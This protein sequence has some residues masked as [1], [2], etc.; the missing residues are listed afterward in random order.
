VIDPADVI[1]EVHE[2][3]NKGFRILEVEG[4]VGVDAVKDPLLPGSYS[5]KQNYPNPFNPQTTIAYDLPR[6]DQVELVVYNTLGQKVATLVSEKQAAGSYRVE[7]N[8]G[9]YASGIYYYKL[10]CA[11]GFT[12]TR[13]LVI[14]K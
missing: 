11:C 13:K 9:R 12:Q 6:A 10:K 14:L 1:T 8:A 3:N 2:N 4:T 5:L 7:W